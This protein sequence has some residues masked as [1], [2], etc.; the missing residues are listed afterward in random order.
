MVISLPKSEQDKFRR[1]VKEQSVENQRKCKD[2][3]KKHTMQLENWV[4]I[5]AASTFLRTTV[6]SKGKY[7]ASGTGNSF[8]GIHQSTHHAF[9]NDGLGGM[10]YINA[11]YAP[12]QEFGTGKY[13]SSGILPGY[14]GYARQFKGHGIR[15]VNIRPHM[16]FFP[17]YERSKKEFIKGLNKM[18]FK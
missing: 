3:V 14:E 4:K 5:S 13:A 2:L 8:Q 18:G 11:H 16:F 15:Q 7:K 12:Y 1:W 9:S 6:K 10:V 17:H